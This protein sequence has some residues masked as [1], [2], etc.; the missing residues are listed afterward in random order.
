MKPI[1]L[2]EGFYEGGSFN[3]TFKDS[4]EQFH[5]IRRNPL[6]GLTCGITGHAIGHKNI[7]PFIDGWQYAMDDPNSLVVKNLH[8]LLSEI[9]WWTL[10]PDQ[11]H[12]MGIKGFGNFGGEHY[13]SV[14]FD[15]K[16]TLAVAYFPDKGKLTVDLSKFSG[17]VRGRWFDPVN[18]NVIPLAARLPNKGEYDFLPPGP[19]ASGKY[20]FLLILES[21]K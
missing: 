16:G 14:A 2:G 1:I 18:G 13:I 3:Y 10:V 17:T 15:P 6:W 12:D 7:F 8:S 4:K 5:A 19:N 21:D 9:S 11:N 20:D